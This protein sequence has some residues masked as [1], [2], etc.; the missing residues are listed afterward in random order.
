[1]PSLV[2]AADPLEM[3]RLFRNRKG[4][5]LDYPGRITEV[6]AELARYVPE[7]SAILRYDIDTV[8]QA[9]AKTIFGKVQPFNR[10]E[11]THRMMSEIW[12]VAQASGD[13]L[14]QLHG[15]AAVV[16]ERQELLSPDRQQP[17]GLPA[18]L[19]DHR[20]PQLQREIGQLG[21]EQEPG[22]EQRSSQVDRR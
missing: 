2:R 18:I 14:Q 21:D 11:E 9:A 15:D 3:R 12:K 8:P 20:A 7:I 1:M 16:D 4:E 22:A 13:G 17:V 5:L 6:R 10:G 19:V